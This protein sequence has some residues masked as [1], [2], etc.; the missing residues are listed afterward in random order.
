MMLIMVWAMIEVFFPTILCGSG[1]GLRMIKIALGAM[2]SQYAVFTAWFDSGAQTNHPSS[3]YPHLWVF[4]QLLLTVYACRLIPRVSVLKLMIFGLGLFYMGASLMEGKSGL[5]PSLSLASGQPDKTVDRPN[6]NLHYAQVNLTLLTRTNMSLLNPGPTASCKACLCSVYPVECSSACDRCPRGTVFHKDCVNKCEFNSN[7]FEGADPSISGTHLCEEHL[8]M[9]RYNPYGKILN[10]MH[11]DKKPD[12]T[13]EEETE[14]METVTDI[15]NRCHDFDTSNFNSSV[16]TLNT[17]K[18]S[19]C[20]YTFMFLNIDGFKSNFDAFVC[21]LSLINNRPSVIGLAETNI[22]EEELKLYQIK[23]YVSVGLS[24]MTGKQKGSGLAIFIK[25]DIP[26]IRNDKLCYSQ[27]EMETLFVTIELKNKSTLLGVTYRPPSSPASSF[28]SSIDSLI[29]QKVPVNNV[30]VMGDFNIDLLKDSTAVEEFG[31]VLTSHGFF[32]LISRAT[33]LKPGCNPS[34]ID[35]I[36]ANSPELCLSSGI[37]DISVSHHRP[38]FVHVF[39]PTAN[40]PGDRR[41]DSK[42]EK[43]IKRK[44]YDFCNANIAKFQDAI[45]S[46]FNTSLYLGSFDD[47]NTVFMDIYE[48]IF[49]STDP[50]KSRRSHKTNPWITHRIVQAINL[51]DKAYKRWRKSKCDEDHETYKEHRRDVR[52]AIKRAKNDHYSGKFDKADGNPKKTWKVI[53]EL[54]GKTKTPPSSTFIVNGVETSCKS[55]ISEK[56]NE[57]FLSIASQLNQDAL[58]NSPFTDV[59]F[60]M[61]SE[62]LSYMPKRV[63]KSMF[64]EDCQPEEILEIIK[65]YSN[66]KSSDISIYALKSVA[67]FISPLLCRYYND[68]MSR[69]VFP[70]ATKLARVTPI[71]KK[72]NKKLFQNYRPVSNLPILGKIFEKIIFNRMYNFLSSESILYD[73]QYG[74]RKHHS[75]SNAL[76]HSTSF[77]LKALSNKEHVLGI[78]IDLSKAFD[79]IDHYKMLKKLECYGIRGTALNLIRSYL[80]DRSQLCE[81]QETKSTSSPI[82]YGVP[83]GSV[84]GPL[85]FLIY[86]NDITNCSTIAEFV[87]FADDTNIFVTGQSLKEVY[88]KANEVLSSVQRYMFCNQLHINAAKCNYMYFDPGGKVT[89]NPDDYHLVLGGTPISRVSSCK[90]LGVFLDDKLS[91]GPHL[92]YL[93]NKLSSQCGILKRLKS[94][95]PRRH[96]LKLY[97]ALF[98]SHLS[99]GITVWGGVSCSRLEKIFVLQKGAS[100]QCSD[101]LIIIIHVTIK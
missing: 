26:F 90:F 14:T 36:M 99:Y 50:P 53:N 91:W 68:F 58:S 27:R 30:M 7:I 65:S 94:T 20:I 56:F 19:N 84:L 98:N 37:I 33:H 13:S 100:E 29:L 62:F 78:F 73:N 24:R 66:G 54:R 101:H 38:I 67:Q 89:R 11:N 9:R 1:L 57:F 51:R 28:I 32:P 39:I 44:H 83:Q 10:D 81:Y 59:N 79:T 80:T 47:F 74:F 52:K 17:D 35:N 21:S 46:T 23:G 71:F 49:I 42:E 55:T 88:K 96:C 85:L 61:D 64:L 22:T 86:I 41:N 2:T 63:S 82:Q 87:L 3:S 60:S 6:K 12:K 97:H 31:P 95:V 18:N 25:E 5:G 48:Q 75:C 40:D 70:N 8:L 92:D 34:C 76:N 16:K 45:N 4:K 77:V 69:G 15:L 43:P 72:G 93:K